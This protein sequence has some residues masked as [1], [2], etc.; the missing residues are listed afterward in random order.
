MDCKRE[1]Y[2]PAQTME[3]REIAEAFE[4]SL[5]GPLGAKIAAFLNRWIKDSPFMTFLERFVPLETEINGKYAEMI[6]TKRETLNLREGD[7]YMNTQTMKSTVTLEN[8]LRTQRE[9]LRIRQ[10]SDDD[11]QALPDESLARLAYEV[12]DSLRREFQTEDQFLSYWRRL[13]GAPANRRSM[14]GPCQSMR[15]P[16]GFYR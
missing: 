10:F 11:L 3:Q 1:A 6:N 12:N 14:R 16:K 7:S 13:Q 9:A 2:E 8:A 4:R 5:D 15:M